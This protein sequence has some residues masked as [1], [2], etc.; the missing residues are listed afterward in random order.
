MPA[1]V[2]VFLSSYSMLNKLELRWKQTG[3]WTEISTIKV[4]ITESKGNQKVNVRFEAVRNGIA[5]VFIRPVVLLELTGILVGCSSRTP[6]RRQ[7]SDSIIPSKHPD[8]LVMLVDAFCSVHEAC[9][10]GASF[11]AFLSLKLLSVTSCSNRSQNHRWS[12]VG[13]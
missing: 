3:L 5:S 10:L 11:C 13:N 4:I 2:L 9:V 6:L 7:C 12:T 8:D 1:G